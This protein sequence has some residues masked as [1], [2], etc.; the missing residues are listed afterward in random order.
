MNLI[1]K[2]QLSSQSLFTGL[3]CSCTRSCLNFHR[4]ISPWAISVFILF[5]SSPISKYP[6]KDQ[7]FPYKWFYYDVVT[8]SN[9]T[10]SNSDVRLS[11]FPLIETELRI[12]LPKLVENQIGTYSRTESKKASS[13]SSL[14]STSFKNF[15]RVGQALPP[16]IHRSPILFREASSLTC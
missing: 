9:I 14:R 12:S 7:I 11:T 10:Q 6:S 1:L 2:H 4:Y 8:V 5:I 15:P 3:S 13:L 16:R